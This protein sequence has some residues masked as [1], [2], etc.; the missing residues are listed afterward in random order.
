M[1]RRLQLKNK[2]IVVHYWGGCPTFI[3][4]KW[5]SYLML[6]NECKER[7]WDNWLVLSKKPENPSLIEPFIES[8]CKII[9]QPRSKGNFDVS[10]IYRNVKL[11]RK[12]KCNVFHCYND[13]TSP[14]IAAAI[15]RVPIRIWSKLSMSSYYEKGIKPKGVQRLMLSTFITCLFSKRVLAITDMVNQEICN[16]VGF[17]S[18]VNTVYTPVSLQRFVE[19]HDVGV[20]GEL[21]F[22]AS[23]IIVVAVG[24]SVEVKG[25]DIAIESFVKISKE[26]PNAKLLLVGGWTSQ[27]FH[28]KLCVQIEK[29]NLENNVFF[30]G[31]RSDIPEVFKA[32][33]IFI[34]PSRSEGMPAALIEAMASGLPC[35]ATASGGI[36]EVIESGINGFLFQRE[37]SD[38]LAD[39]VI[40]LIS[41]P[42]LRNDFTGVAKENLYK[43]SLE[44]YVSTVIS[45]YEGTSN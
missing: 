19:A 30:T 1:I 3:T 39:K 45:Y 27:Q 32:S 36:P 17:T 43:F 31:I 9:Y 23:D 7:G 28:Q 12:V 41:E 15:A 25:W 42:K 2:K 11:L 13:H 22:K 24:H 18:K 44:R 35:V 14:L 26:I 33:D 6:V 29:L 5:L 21:Q 20:R 37:N 34:L 10:S 38:D 16:Q 4:S 40:R 8:G